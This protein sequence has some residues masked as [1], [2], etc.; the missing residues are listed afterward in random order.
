MKPSFKHYQKEVEFALES[1][2]LAAGV[3]KSVRAQM[4]QAAFTK[5]DESPVTIAD[6]A[7]QAVV[8]KFLKDQFP[9]D[10]LV[11]EENASE[12]RK[13]EGGNTVQRIG[14]FLEPV[15]GRQSAET[16]FDW[17][18][19]GSQE[20]AER[21]W[22]MD[23]IDGT[24]GFIR[25]DQYAVALALIEKGD[26]KVSVM[27]CPNLT[28]GNTPDVGGP[29]TL[30]CA[31]RGE[32]TWVTDLNGKGEWKQL[33]ASKHTAGNEAIILRSFEKKH[34]DSPRMI[35]FANLLGLVHPPVLMDSLAKYVVLSSGA[36]DLLLRFPLKDHPHEWIWDQAPGVIL[37]EEAGGRAS[38]LDGKP[39]DFTK[40]RQL[41][42]NRGILMSNGALHDTILSVLKQIKASN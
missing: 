28:G 9:K 25:G 18:D 41:K 11:G 37:I 23:P 16:I 38:D 17:I 33:R 22:T 12:L 24:K 39:L 29:G 3:V 31:V 13:E 30:A 19:H 42:A 14:Q 15:L 34:T 21:F 10:P 2:R 1:I 32:G 7:A 5:Q 6:F 35:E 4:V 20:P 8:A 36:A 27:A 26:I 40:G